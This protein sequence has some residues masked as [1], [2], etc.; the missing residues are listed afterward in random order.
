MSPEGDVFDLMAGRNG[1]G[2]N[3]GVYLKG[4]AGDTLRIDRIGRPVEYVRQPA[5]TMGLAVQPDVLS[6]LMA[7]R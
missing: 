3:L 5:L 1:N 7:S 2:P 6:G 4:H